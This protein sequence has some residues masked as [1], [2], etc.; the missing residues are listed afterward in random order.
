MK[1]EI[2][3]DVMLRA[4]VSLEQKRQLQAISFANQC[5]L[6]DVVR[7]AIREY[8]AAHNQDRPEP[9]P[10]PPPPPPETLQPEP[11]RA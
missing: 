3:L 5:S 7:T 9:S 8:L 4:R 2:Q 10:A 11:A 6:S 1:N